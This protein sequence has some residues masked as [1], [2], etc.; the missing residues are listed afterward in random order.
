MRIKGIKI[1]E[2]V[3]KILETENGELLRSFKTTSG[4]LAEEHKIDEKTIN[5]LG[6]DLHYDIIKSEYFPKSEE[7]KTFLTQNKITAK[8]VNE[9][10][11]DDL[12]K[13]LQEIVKSELGKDYKNMN[14]IGASRLIGIPTS[15]DAKI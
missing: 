7:E 13:I 14:Y 2:D 8:L 6:V 9:E 11:L 3:A 12:E 15:I 10:A 4:V 5:I 1:D